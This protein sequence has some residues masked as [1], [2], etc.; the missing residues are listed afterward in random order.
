MRES[1]VVVSRAE[2]RAF[3]LKLEEEGKKVRKQ[4]EISKKKRQQNA[5]D[6]GSFQRK[7][8]KTLFS[9]QFAKLTPP[10]NTTHRPSM[11]CMLQ[12][13]HHITVRASAR[14]RTQW[15]QSR[16]FLAQHPLRR[17]RSTA[18]DTALRE[19]FRPLGKGTVHLKWHTHLPLALIQL[20][21]PAKM[22]AMSGKMMAELADQLR[23]TPGRS[24]HFMVLFRMIL[25][26]KSAE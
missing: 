20:D 6:G 18:S 17:H 2:M 5:L 7:S 12:R 26:L 10:T 19:Q 9:S 16:V 25:T 11:Y 21:H 23:P 3:C 4:F 13:Q 24:R 22:N 8:P 1:R 15:I 14:S